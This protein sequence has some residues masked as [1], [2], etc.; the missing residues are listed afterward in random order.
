MRQQIGIL[1]FS[2]LVFGC[3]KNQVERRSHDTAIEGAERVETERRQVEGTQITAEDILDGELLSNKRL[4]YTKE[5]QQAL[6]VLNETVAQNQEQLQKYDKKLMAGCD[7]NLSGCVNISFF[8]QD[9][10]SSSVAIRIAKDQKDIREYYRRILVAID[11][12]NSVLNTDL[13][14]AYLERSA[15]L[16][17]HF[18]TSA[19]GSV[20]AEKHLRIIHLIL[21]SNSQSQNLEKIRAL[22]SKVSPWSYSKQNVTSRSE[23]SLFESMVQMSLYQNG[24]L[25]PDLLAFLSEQKKQR[26]GFWGNQQEVFESFQ[27]VAKQLSVNRYEDLNESIYLAE[28]LYL[29]H[30][31]QDA[32][33]MIW[34]ASS[35]DQSQM[36]KAFK[37]LIQTE[38]L[39]QLRKSHLKFQKLFMDKENLAVGNV[40]DDIVNRSGEISEEWK[41]FVSRT[42]RVLSFIKALE[43]TQ[44]LSAQAIENLKFARQIKANIKM[45]VI[46]PQMMMLSYYLGKNNFSKQFHLPWGTITIDSTDVIDGFFSGRWE[47]WF[48]YGV[49]LEPLSSIEIL[50]SFHF[51]LMTNTFEVFSVDVRDFMQ[52]VFE[53]LLGPKELKLKEE[54]DFLLSKYSGSEFWM[55]YK[56][57]CEAGKQNRPVQSRYSLSDLSTSAYMGS[58]YA[59]VNSSGTGFSGSHRSIGNGGASISVKETDVNPYSS[60]TIEMLERVRLQFNP[61]LRYMENM[62]EIYR[63][64]VSSQQSSQIPVTGKD[65]AQIEEAIGSTKTEISNFLFYFYSYS[66]SFDACYLATFQKEIQLQVHVLKKEV[67]YLRKIHAEMTLARTTSEEVQKLNQKYELQNMPNGFKGF[68]R[69]DGD[70]LLYHPLDFYV[71][72]KHSLENNPFA[73]QFTIDIPTNLDELS[74]YNEVTAFSIRYDEN[75]EN[76][77]ASA[78]QLLVNP[79]SKFVRWFDYYFVD[80]TNW[81]EKLFAKAILYRYGPVKLGEQTFEITADELV[82]LPLQMI[83]GL[84]IPTEL[85]KFYIQSGLST[86]YFEIIM[87]DI[88]T[89]PTFQ[90]PY[91]YHD[92]LFKNIFSDYI[93]N[94]IFSG[95]GFV[96]SYIAQFTSIMQEVDQYVEH[97]N[98]LRGVSFVFDK[99]DQKVESLLDESMTK[100]VKTDLDRGLLLKGKIQERYKADLAKKSVLPFHAEVGKTYQGTYLSESV[101]DN[102]RARIL[103]YKR[104]GDFPF[105]KAIKNY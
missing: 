16:L 56:A 22:L 41:L 38:F 33:L 7:E 63:S 69:F 81:R 19:K 104:K 77:I 82:E 76:F 67:E 27:A 79:N 66:Q 13:H 85:E 101:T 80:L 102:F 48:D 50:H 73:V 90:T 6:R 21:K 17:A 68:N 91:G 103:D 49:G 53:K 51:A 105:T 42:E 95:D 36:V 78:L 37:S 20:L 93:G 70:I 9:S 100:L 46:Y 59:K 89:H 86:R 74:V 58:N 99:T 15:E 26:T 28:R 29:G 10:L 65:I 8:R 52:V 2:V 14:A 4:A 31:D 98:K 55:K 83:Q 5:A 43:N 35:K 84:N 23:H 30:L 32:A 24:K 11:L 72:A 71:R 40:F 75:V 60:R 34:N 1:F 62:I 96:A 57:M 88:W 3:T 12:S 39:F 25:N 92:Y 44:Q 87:R 54:R 97:K 18:S 94:F 45:M 47:P 64:H 61:L